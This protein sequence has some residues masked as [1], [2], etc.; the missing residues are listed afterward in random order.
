LKRSLIFC[1]AFCRREDYDKIGGWNTK[2]EY[3]YEDWDFWLSIIE[4]G[5]EVYKLPQTHFYY[6]IRGN[7]ITRT[8]DFNERIKKELRK[9]YLNHQKLYAEHFPDPLNLYN[10]NQRMKISHEEQLK[11]IYNTPD[12]KLGNNILNPFRKIK[13]LLSK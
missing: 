6:R 7:S 13:S 12:Y 5:R 4:L 3:F 1:T 8:R 10:E 2:M 11:W 9:L